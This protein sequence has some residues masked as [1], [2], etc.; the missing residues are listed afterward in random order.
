MATARQLKSGKWRCDAYLGRDK[1]GKKL[2]KTFVTD[3]RWEAE[4][5]AFEFAR[6]NKSKIPDFSVGDAVSG[7]IDLKRNILSP[8]TINGY[9]IIRRNRLPSLMKL[10]VHE[11]SSLTM[12]KAI[13]EDSVS[14]GAKTLNEAKNL[15]MTALKL[16][17]IRP[18]IHVTL[19]AKKPVI[20]NLPD[21]AVVIKAI[22]GTDLELP[23]MLALW[24][25]LR[26]SEV[27]GLQ[28]GDIKKGYVTIQR[29]K[30]C[31]KGQDH[32]RD[33]N[34]TYNSTRTL[35][36]P[37]YLLDMIKAIPHEKDTDFIVDI[38]YQNLSR[39]FKKRMKEEGWNMH[40]HDL[41][42]LNASVML[43]LGIP[44]KYAM[45]RGGWS[46]NSTLKK[47]Y[48]HTFSEKRKLVDKT[49]DDYFISII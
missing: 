39:W 4:K 49:I 26:I 29:S 42:H 28:F 17:G 40:F 13:N 35:E 47:V 16:Y 23:C 2:T 31:F 9:E 44:D 43:Q 34:K 32:I 27:R 18:D 45:E 21:P 19:P 1:D 22:K 41:R 14:V 10:D 37:K 8:S 36:M 33:V 30:I 7:Y 46:T 25:S 48:Q 20:K 38:S 6:D 11:V 5:L 15:V 24:L 12:Q 3:Q